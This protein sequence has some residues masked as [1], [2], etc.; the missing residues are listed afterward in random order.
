[1]SKRLSKN[2][3]LRASAES[4]LAV[5]LNPKLSAYLNFGKVAAGDVTIGDMVNILSDKVILPHILKADRSF[6]Q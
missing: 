3:T 6:Y 2:D 4:K 1:M 5:T